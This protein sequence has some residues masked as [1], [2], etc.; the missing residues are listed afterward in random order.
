[1][2][3]ALMNASNFGNMIAMDLTQAT[4]G[5]VMSLGVN[6]IIKKIAPEQALF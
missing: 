5:L 3:R 2:Y 1:M 6:F 4:I